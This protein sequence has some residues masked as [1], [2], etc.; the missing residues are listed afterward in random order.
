MNVKKKLFTAA[1]IC[2]YVG[3][4]LW[5]LAAACEFAV[6]NAIYYLFAAF[7]I[8]AVCTGLCSSTLKT[9]IKKDDFDKKDDI[10]F[11]VYTVL[12]IVVFPATI[13]Y[14]VAR[15]G[16]F[17]DKEI[18]AEAPKN[19]GNA[20]NRTPA[21]KTSEKPA[22]DA[23]AKKQS[24]FK[25]KSFIVSVI[26]VAA[27]IFSSFSAMLFE[28]SGFFVKVNDFKL[29]KEMTEEYNS[30]PL[31]GKSWVIQNDALSYTVTE[32]IPKT[33]TKENPA[34]VIFVM[35][36]FTRT[37]TTMAQYAIEYS[38]R[39]AVVFVID[40]GC[41]GGTT[42]SGYKED[43][44]MISSTVGA[45][46]LDYLVQYV[47]ANTDKYDFIDRE[48]IGAIGHSAGGG[49]VADV[50]EQFAGYNYGDSIIKSLYISGYIKV[51][52]ANR[53][54][55]LRC[56]AGLSY[57]YYDEGEY[58]YQSDSAAFEVIASRFVNEVYY[59]SS[60]CAVPSKIYDVKEDFGY[61]NKED[62]TY[63][64]IHRE[65]TNHCFEMY[66][67]LSITNSISFF[68]ETL[69]FGGDIK[70]SSQTWFGKEAFNGLALVSA[71]TLIVAFAY[72]L[73]ETPFFNTIRTKRTKRVA[74]A[75]AEGENN[76]NAVDD[77]LSCGEYAAG[78][79]GK[80]KR[81]PNAADK[82]TFW[83]SMIV[84]GVIA[85]L[86][87]IPLANV[88]IDMFPDAASN[89]FTFFFPARMVNA[90]LL[91]A[92]V[93]G[94]V[95]L[96]IFFGTVLIK[97]LVRKEKDFSQLEPLKIN[98]IQLLKTLLL[99]AILVATFYGL[100][101]LSIAVFHEDFRFMLISASALTPRYIVTALMYLPLFFI[102]YIQNSIRV[103]CGVGFE[104]WKEWKVQLV[105]ALANSL[106]LVFILVINYFCFFTTGSVFYGYMGAGNEVWLY[107]NMVF[108]LVI[109]MAL[110]PIMNR[111]FYKK[112]HNVWLGAI[113]CCLIFVTMTMTA[114]VSY[115]AM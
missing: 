77:A 69:G 37:R 15:F 106:G 60:N 1:E 35:P 101:H 95:G 96:A 63:R 17:A 32:Y 12:S 30:K 67:A 48:S 84:S 25:K 10:R 66:D 31:N 94:L 110:L 36:G 40:P 111:L 87:F 26:C 74:A 93:N 39:G 78:I 58:R 19:A 82:I 28:T 102:F 33:A 65:K 3:T 9:R 113:V 29:T 38:R 100:D 70:V 50:A 91:W 75:Y 62:G 79:E 5:L 43:G 24:I 13:L 57:A 99:A 109:M 6:S 80:G 107:I 27:I 89:T 103:N 68:T 115:I 46:G 2:L 71:M 56:N 105:G 22:A 49:N 47:Y 97:N 18:A 7:G 16:K 85:C 42:Y 73:M 4:F 59:S 8:I 86:D 14:I 114:S 45:N 23:S 51:S 112:T 98:G 54:K 55:N 34:P 76:G 20:E 88:S 52:S 53:Y 83:L 72:F 90:V 92:V 21:D 108:P 64:I 41:Q 61:G 44:S 11:I 104:G 81:K